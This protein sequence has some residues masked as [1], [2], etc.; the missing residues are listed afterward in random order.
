MS[1]KVFIT[2]Y[3]ETLGIVECELINHYPP[4]VRVMVN[5]SSVYVGCNYWNETK[6]AAEKI[7]ASIAQKKIAGY[8]KK[9]A[10]LKKW[11]PGEEDGRIM[12]I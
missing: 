8:E 1:K 7:A 3:L 10:K 12:S 6:E 5:G 4:G 2:K 11:L 9:I